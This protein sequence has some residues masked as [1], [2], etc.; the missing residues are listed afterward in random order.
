MQMFKIKPLKIALSRWGLSTSLPNL[1]GCS[2]LVPRARACLSRAAAGPRG[3]EEMQAGGPEGRASSAWVRFHPHLLSPECEQILLQILLL[4][5]W[6]SCWCKFL[7]Q[8]GPFRLRGP[9]RA[10]GAHGP[11]LTA[12]SP[13]LLNTDAVPC[14]LLVPFSQGAGCLQNSIQQDD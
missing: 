9:V 7:G 11:P 1:R 12:N 2:G 3:T 5:G 10:Q 14:L 13:A 4:R 8:V 6:S